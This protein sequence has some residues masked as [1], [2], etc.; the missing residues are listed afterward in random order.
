M[1][2]FIEVKMLNWEHTC[3]YIYHI[4]LLNLT[5]C[6]IEQMYNFVQSPLISPQYILDWYDYLKSYNQNKYCYM[7][8]YDIL[9]NLWNENLKK[10]AGR[11]L[12]KEIS[13]FLLTNQ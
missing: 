6:I 8:K 12:L 10:V 5:I 9:I 4:N 13:L 3:P 11:N 1:K 7:S 2:Y